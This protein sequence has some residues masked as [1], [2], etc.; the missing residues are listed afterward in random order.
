[1]SLEIPLGEQEHLKE[2]FE[3]ADQHFRD[4]RLKS[5]EKLIQYIDSMEQ[6]YTD[7]C[8]EIEYLKEQLQDMKDSSL[9]GKMTVLHNDLQEQFFFMGRKTGKF[10]ADISEQTKKF[11]MGIR[12]GK[13]YVL[14]QFLNGLQIKGYLETAR[15]RLGYLNQTLE[16]GLKELEQAGIKEEEAKAHK[17]EAIAVLRGKKVKDEKQEGSAGRKGILQKTLIYMKRLC[18]GME[19]RTIKM[20]QVIEKGNDLQPDKPKI[21]WQSKVRPKTGEERG[22]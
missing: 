16:T 17:K 3:L 22:R 19:Q 6:Q 8:E 12:Q 20:I 2:F 1:M 4:E 7:M 14:G 18:E 11:L 15:E 9:K 13:N 21:D 10:K 5:Y